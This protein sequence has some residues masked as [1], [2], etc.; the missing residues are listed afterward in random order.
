MTTEA[1]KPFAGCSVC[2]YN[3]GGYC[4]N[5]NPRCPNKPDSLPFPPAQAPAAEPEQPNKRQPAASR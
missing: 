1:P 5:A 2:E 3:C 4:G